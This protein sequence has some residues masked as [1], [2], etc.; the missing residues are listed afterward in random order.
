V[1]TRQLTLKASDRKPPELGQKVRVEV[2]HLSPAGD[3]AALAV[4][5]NGNGLSDR[6]KD[7]FLE[8][9]T[10]AKNMWR[11]AC[12][13]NLTLEFELPEAVALGVIEV[14]NYNSEWQTQD[15]FRKADV[16][17]STDGTTWQTV[18]HGAEFAEAEGNRDYD[19]PIRLKLNGVMARKVRFEHIV[20]WGGSGKVGLSKVV[21]HQ[22]IGAQA[23]SNQPE[24]SATGVA[25]DKQ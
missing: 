11:G 4:L 14:W 16:A 24:N 9:D 2:A 15:G 1:L 25:A 17:V 10:D 21:F 7:G 13:T 5:L 18:L 23:G 8:H 19:E 6:D 12:S 20:P 22:A 3:D